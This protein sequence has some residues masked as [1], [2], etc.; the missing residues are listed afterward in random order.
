MKTYKEFII[1]ASTTSDGFKALSDHEKIV[2]IATRGL[3]SSYA[4]ISNYRFHEANKDTGISSDQ[5]DAAKQNLIGK[6]YIN[7]RGALTTL[8]KTHAGTIY[9]KLINYKA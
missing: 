3:K 7:A 8:G 2:M 6:K 1:E 9:D 5:W 4:G